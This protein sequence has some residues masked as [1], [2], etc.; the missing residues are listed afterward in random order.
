MKRT[1]LF[2]FLSLLAM[3]MFFNSCRYEDFSFGS[4]YRAIVVA[5]TGT[6]SDGKAQFALTEKTFRTLTDFNNLDGKFA[7]IKRGGTLHVRNINGS[8]V[9]A[10]SFEGGG[11]PSLRYTVKSGVASALDYSTLAL[12]SAYYQLDEIYSTVE[13]KL[14]LSPTA[15]Q[16]K[17]PGG[18]HT[19]LFE[20]EIKMNDGEGE[21]TAGV[22]LNAAFSPSDKK[23]LL[24]QRSPVER[25]P[26]SSNF[27]VITHEFG[28][29]VFDY[30]FYAGAS[31][32]TDRWSDEWSINGFNEG[33]ADFVSWA[34]TDSTDILRSSIDIP[35]VANE[36]DFSKTIFTFENLNAE[37]PTACS[38][39]FYC[40]GTIFAR[41][42]FEV[43]TSLKATVSKKDMAKGVIE[44]LSKCKALLDT[45]D[46]S[47]LPEKKDRDSLNFPEL[48]EYDGKVAGSFLRAF[49]LSAPND[50]KAELCNAFRD[51][52]GT[53]GFPS[54]AR[55]GSCDN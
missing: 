40:V 47:I 1:N 7:T 15:L 22:K 8:I 23:F 3:S 6:A 55:K 17:L 52:F 21:I 19:I 2:F 37:K 24:F 14:G 27:Q 50:W 10:D 54:A 33:F 39:D 28:H 30:T 44:T 32:P 13:D 20:P 48:Y 16:E 4:P 26:L 11:Q 43:W 31:K 46:A 36:R 35:Q 34:F 38:G 42:L 18:K 29:F 5:F 53:H 12:L 51:N 41:S 49:V 25:V 45:M 9:S